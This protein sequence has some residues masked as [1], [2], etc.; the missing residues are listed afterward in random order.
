MQ[1]IDF[2]TD[3]YILTVTVSGARRSYTKAEL[4]AVLEGQP[5][6]TPRGRRR[7]AQKPDLASTG[8][9]SEAA[10]IR[11]ITESGT[12]PWVAKLAATVREVAK[13]DPI[14]VSEQR[15]LA[16]ILNAMNEPQ[17]EKTTSRLASTLENLHATE[18][19]LVEAISAF[20]ERYPGL[21]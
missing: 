17:P 19:V 10:E 20:V 2:D 21:R 9:S 14:P 6:V 7:G 8:A 1:L 4:V 3:Q 15:R 16:R 12:L 11:R 13:H 18:A 5:S